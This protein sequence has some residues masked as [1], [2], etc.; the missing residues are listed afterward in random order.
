M[1]KPS[2]NTGQVIY[3]PTDSTSQDKLFWDD[4]EWK[5]ICYA[6]VYLETPLEIPKPGVLMGYRDALQ[7]VSDIEDLENYE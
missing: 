2:K 3:N 1:L 6:R 4:K 7:M 5:D